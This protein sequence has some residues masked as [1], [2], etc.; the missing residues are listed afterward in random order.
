MNDAKDQEKELSDIDLCYKALG[1]SVGDS[2]ERIDM[3]YN[4][5]MGMSKSDL[6]S[7]D[8]A[9]REEAKNSIALV[10]QMYEN[11]KASVTYQSMVKEYSKSNAREKETQGI[12]PRLMKNI[13]KE[14]PSCRS[15]ISKAVKTCP[16]CKFVY[17]TFSEKLFEDYLTPK[18]IIIIS[19]VVV[20]GLCAY[21]G[22][23]NPDLIDKVLSVF[24]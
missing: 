8:P 6:A 18:H 7:G 12:D 17:K 10:N 22:I 2:P 14:C 23:Q 19:V 13:Y 5:L 16:K 4:R 15:I 3:T 9:V 20:V 11:I 21:I 1:L 24:R